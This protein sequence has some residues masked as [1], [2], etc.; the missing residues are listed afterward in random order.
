MASVRHFVSKQRDKARAWKRGGRTTVESLDAVDAEGRYQREPV[1]RLTP[2]DLYERRWA[3]TLLGRALDALRAEALSEGREREFER[4]Q[5]LLT[6]EGADAPYRQIATELGTTEDAVK[7]A[8]HRLR[9]RFGAR[10]RT[11][12]AATVASPNEVD[13]EVRYLLRVIASAKGGP[14]SSP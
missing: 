2:E 9:R 4:L 7:T 11:E 14:V 8:V 10:L 3:L 5:G 13:D 1:D 6:G 12:I